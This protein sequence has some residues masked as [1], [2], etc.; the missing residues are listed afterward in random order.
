MIL[1]RR[2]VEQLG[3]QRAA[4]TGKMFKE[5]YPDMQINGRYT[6]KLELAS[7]PHAV[8]ETQRAFYLVPWRDVMERYRG[9][10]ITGRSLSGSISW[11]LR[12]RNRG[13]GR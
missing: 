11:E 1:R 5:Q 6:E 13:L 12:S 7:G 9:R 4:E 8:I 2:E 10:Q 3:E